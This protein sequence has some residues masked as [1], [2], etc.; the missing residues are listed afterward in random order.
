M[1]V[2]QG[3][4]AFALK[5]KGSASAIRRE[6]Y[7]FYDRDPALQTAFDSYNLRCKAIGDLGCMKFG[8]LCMHIFNRFR[9]D[10]GNG[11]LKI[12]MPRKIIRRAIR[13]MGGVAFTDYRKGTQTVRFLIYAAGEIA[14][15]VRTGR[16]GECR[17]SILGRMDD[18][19]NALMRMTAFSEDER[20]LIKKSLDEDFFS[21]ITK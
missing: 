8:A 3:K 10:K 2:Q 12:C 20:G 14:D 17:K 11:P 7:C 16:S 4:P 6:I 9:K 5:A 15:L 13:E 21:R 18:K 19:G 1:A